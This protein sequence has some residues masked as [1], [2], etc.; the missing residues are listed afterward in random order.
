VTTPPTF[1]INGRKVSGPR[2]VAWLD[3]AFQFTLRKGSELLASG[4]P[5]GEITRRLTDEELR[6]AAGIR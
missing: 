6:V 3:N 1:L 4:V 5:A 2:P